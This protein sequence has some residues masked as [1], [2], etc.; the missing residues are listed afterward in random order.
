MG[1]DYLLLGHAEPDRLRRLI[2]RLLPGG[3]RVFV[4]YDR[5]SPRHEFRSL[6]IPPDPDVVPIRRRRSG[7]GTFGIVAA[8]LDGMHRYVRKGRSSHLVF[9]SGT[10]YPLKSPEAIAAHFA[11]NPG[12]TFID[13]FPLPFAG[14]PGHAGGAGRWDRWYIAGRELPPRSRVPAGHGPRHLPKGLL[15]TGGSQWAALSRDTVVEVL[16]FLERRP[17]V[18]RFFRFTLIPDEV[19]I[20]TVLATLGIEVQAGVHYVDWSKGLPRSLTVEDVPQLLH[21]RHLYARKFVSQRP[22]DEIDAALRS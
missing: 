17:D 18:H 1:P 21:G 14:W 7:W 8:M 6:L 16:A 3:G 2:D 5:R 11:G 20:P 9:L 19:L 15:A 12:V 22:L 4:H 10:D 13:T